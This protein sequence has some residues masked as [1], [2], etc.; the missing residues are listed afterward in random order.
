VLTT[1]QDLFTFSKEGASGKMK[2]GEGMTEVRLTVPEREGSG[3][4][5]SLW[6][7]VR[8]EVDFQPV[9]PLVSVALV[10]SL[11][12]SVGQEQG[13]LHAGEGAGS[14][15][16]SCSPL[17]LS[18]Q[19]QM[20]HEPWLGQYLNY[21]SLKQFIKRIGMIEAES[22]DASNFDRRQISLSDAEEGLWLSIQQQLAKVNEFMSK[23]IQSIDEELTAV[24][25]QI[26]QVGGSTRR[27]DIIVRIQRCAVR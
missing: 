27:A 13:G 22:S 26:D 5:M 2:F 6:G 20:M 4:S 19:S 23:E 12:E 25:A 24:S 11:R 1:F 21:G 15:G 16:R 18:R 8:E 14:P 17:N 9:P 10:G 3:I 7:I